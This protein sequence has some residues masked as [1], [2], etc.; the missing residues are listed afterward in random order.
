MAIATKEMLLSI[1]QIQIH[2]GFLLPQTST[3]A[4]Q[5]LLNGRG[6]L[7]PPI[8]LSAYPPVTNVAQPD[9][10]INGG[11]FVSGYFLTDVKRPVLSIPKFEEYGK[12]SNTFSRTI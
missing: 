7:A 12:A 10:A 6:Q 9:L 3:P 4:F 2:S 1:Q 8:R 11:G 5:E